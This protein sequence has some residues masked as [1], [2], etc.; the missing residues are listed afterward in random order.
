MRLF[1]AEKPSLGRAIAAGL[2]NQKKSEGCI[3]CGDDVVTWCFGHMLELAWPKDYKPEY[4][5]WRR[6]H[7]PIIPS[8]WKYKVKK[9]AAAQ[10]NII[11]SLLREADA[12]V[13]AGDPDREGQLLVDEVLEH[14]HYTGR[15]ERIW[16]ASLDDLSVRK[17]LAN[18]TDNTRYAPLRDAARARSRA[19]WLA[20]INAT[21]ALT[22]KVRAEG[23]S[24]VLSLGRVQTPTL[25]LV[26]AR[27]LE[28]SHFK[29]VD[30]FVLRA[31]L[32]HSAGDFAVTFA[33][34]E[35]QAGL[36]AS[37]HL[38]DAAVAE[39]LVAAHTNTDG[40]VTEALREAKS[41]AAPLPHSLSSLQKA[42]SSKLGMSAQQVLYTA[43]SLYEK[44]L[45]TYPRTDCRYLPEEQFADSSA[46]L[47]A[48]SSVP[49]LKQVAGTADAS[50]KSVAWNTKKVT[51]HHAIAPTGEVPPGSLPQKE[52]DLYLMIATAFC[53]QFHPTMRYEA[54]KVAVSLADTRWEATGRRILDP[55]WTAFSGHDD[56]DGDSDEQSLPPLEQGDAVHCRDIQTQKKQTSPPSHFT[57][58][59]LI[60][61]MANVHRFVADADAK[62]TLKE[63]KGIGTEATRARVLETLKERGYLA[64][65]KKALVS[66]PLGREI[67][68]L[69]PPA[70]KDPITTAEWESRLEAIAQGTESLDA[71][72]ADQC[73]VLPDLL[74][75]ILGDGKPAFPCPACGAALT[76]RKRKKDGA[77]FWG[78][79]AYPECKVVLPDDN[80]KP[81]KSRAKAALSEYACPAC[82]KPLVKRSG[83]KGDFYG[84][85]G[86][87]ECKNLC[88][89]KPDGSP[90]FGAKG[91]RK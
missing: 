19:D 69:T 50:L 67:I 24:D 38:T 68:D 63:T 7:L 57:E 66:T 49:D 6:E 85:S 59:S 34:S 90:D 73:R 55:G 86:Y 72:L 10:L 41:K 60:E 45:T 81:G 31:S 20:G 65:D 56:E 76:R 27:D 21:R 4:T 9:D 28:I 15:V 2:E 43:Q 3:R 89:V 83:T 48:L 87:P 37:G 53:L 14:F 82:G 62:N 8:Q 77:W 40:L 51:A 29:P 42:A 11:G 39:A 58:G 70:L 74:A 35:D 47:A 32:A 16:L 52:H 1:I 64:A 44:R 22:I 78:C 75:P 84:C 54:Q 18:L 79:T 17:A 46:V 61:A 80:G 88:P 5:Q 26:V 33:P 71:F 36:D 12:V 91:R 13:N 25:A 23:R 30:Y